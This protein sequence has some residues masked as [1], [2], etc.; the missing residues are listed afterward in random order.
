MFHRGICK[1][2]G[3]RFFVLSFGTP[4][5]VPKMALPVHF[6]KSWD[7]RRL[8]L[9]R[10]FRD[11]KS[12]VSDHKET[13]YQVY[14]VVEGM[15]SRQLHVMLPW[16]VIIYCVGPQIII[17]H[18]LTRKGLKLPNK[19]VTFVFQCFCLHIVNSSL[20]WG[21]LGSGWICLHLPVCDRRSC[22]GREISVSEISLSWKFTFSSL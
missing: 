20:D 19:V 10:S 17:G 4:N 2:I 18:Y 14:S 21:R 3:F 16:F 9:S 15:C 8:R 13:V 6:I 12:I 1:K 22:A 5:K 7:T 11:T